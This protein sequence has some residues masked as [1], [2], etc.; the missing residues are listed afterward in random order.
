ML[1]GVPFLILWHEAEHT[2]RDRS[3][4]PAYGQF[5]EGHRCHFF[6][7]HRHSQR[8]QPIRKW[9][10]VYAF[11]SDNNNRPWKEEPRDGRQKL[12]FPEEQEDTGK[13]CQNFE[14]A[15]PPVTIQ[16]Y[17]ND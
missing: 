6:P 14:D 3:F 5:G 9:P 7:A 1:E 16:E 15:L 11:V 8:N 17:G 13:Q 2:V 10:V 12:R 4:L